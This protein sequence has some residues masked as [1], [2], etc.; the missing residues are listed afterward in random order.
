[1]TDMSYDVCI[2]KESFN[3]TYNLSKFFYD[4]IDGGIPALDGITGKRATEVLATAFEAIDRT[5]TG[6]CSGDILDNAAFC[7]EYDAPN[8]WGST[9]G[10]IIFL[11]RLLAACAQ[12]PR[13]MVAV[14]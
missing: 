9:V 2:G 7:K 10:A 12:N 14:L 11:S 1:M 5:R 3:Y 6:F 13:K 8:G 4:H